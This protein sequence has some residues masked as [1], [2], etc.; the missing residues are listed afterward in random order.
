MGR[1]RNSRRKTSKTK[2]YKKLAKTANRR[3]D[4]DQIQDELEKQA[5]TGKA[6]AFEVDEDLPGMG[7]F[8]CT[9][10]ARHFADQA[11]LSEH[12]S[13][14]LHKRRLKDVAQNKYTQ[15]EADRAAGKTKEALPPAHG[16]GGGG[17]ASEGARAARRMSI[18]K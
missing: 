2:S 1:V 15:A 12:E 17:S 14:K 8:Y 4:I 6:M 16:G 11:T 18:D 3:K 5:E 10:C 9:P 7:Q 13:T